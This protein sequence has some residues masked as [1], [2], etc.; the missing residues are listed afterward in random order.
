M[1]VLNIDGYIVLSA[2]QV[3]KMNAARGIYLE[4]GGERLFVKSSPNLQGTVR[5]NLE[6]IRGTNVRRS[7]SSR[8]LSK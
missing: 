8:R 1:N 5:I 3:T 2:A 7:T 4:I 6:R